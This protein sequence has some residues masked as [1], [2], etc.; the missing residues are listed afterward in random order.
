MTEW[1]TVVE[2]ALGIASDITEGIEGTERR[3][4]GADEGGGYQPSLEPNS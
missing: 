4:D 1:V 2:P 3:V